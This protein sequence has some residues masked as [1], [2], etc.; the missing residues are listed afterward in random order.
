MKTIKYVQYIR[1]NPSLMYTREY[2]RPP[3]LLDNLEIPTGTQLQ[4]VILRDIAVK[5]LA[6]QLQK[7]RWKDVH[8]YFPQSKNK[9]Q[10]NGLPG[11]KEKTN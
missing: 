9:S 2:H 10:L 5:V 11:L 8:L 4:L 7:V 1:T 3:L 6:N